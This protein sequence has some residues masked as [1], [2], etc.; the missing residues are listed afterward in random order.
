[1]YVTGGYILM[2]KCRMFYVVGD[3]VITTYAKP[4]DAFLV[5]VWLDNTCDVVHI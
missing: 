2:D 3:E 1:M 4:V 5:D